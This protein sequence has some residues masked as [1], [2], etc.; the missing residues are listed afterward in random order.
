MF[1][2]QNSIDTTAKEYVDRLFSGVEPSQQLFDLK[3]ELTISVRERLLREEKTLVTMIKLYC[4][5]LK[6]AESIP[7]KDCSELIEY[8]SNRLINCKFGAKKP[9]CAKCKIHCYEAQMRSRIRIVMKT[10]GTKMVLKHPVL[11]LKHMADTIM[12]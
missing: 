4:K 9:V 3:E 1:N 11:L 5:S 2:K 12:Y 6:H 8:A 10:A 7:C